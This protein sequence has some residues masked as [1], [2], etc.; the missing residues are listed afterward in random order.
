MITI[1]NDNKLRTILSQWFCDASL[2]WHFIE[3]FDMKNNL[4]RQINLAFWYQAMINRFKKR[5]SSALSTLQNFKYTLIDA[6]SEKDLRLYAQQNFRSIKTVNMN[7]IHN[8][9]TIT[10]NNLDWRF[11]AN[12]L[13]STIITFIRKFLIQLHFM[14]NIWQEIIRSQSQNQFKFI[15]D[16]FQNSRRTPNSSEY[17]VRSNVFSFSCQY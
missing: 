11:W 16:R 2:I 17:L 14:L 4:L 7:S 3:L 13:E 6:Q 15:K 1:R 8:Q 5:T 12:I 9:L 10:W